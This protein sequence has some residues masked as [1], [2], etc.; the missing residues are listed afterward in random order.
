MPTAKTTEV[1]LFEE[2]QGKEFV[3]VPIFG[4]KFSFLAGTNMFALLNVFN[5]DEPANLPKYLIDRVA[6]RDQKR[7]VTALGQR[8]DLSIDE[9]IKIFNDITA[10]QAEGRPTN[11]STGSSSGSG[12][13][14]ASTRSA[15]T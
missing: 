11:S 3:E 10:A 12:K 5:P 2:D 13:R 7:L 8:A 1:E 4:E 9:L 6:K 15:D 14:A